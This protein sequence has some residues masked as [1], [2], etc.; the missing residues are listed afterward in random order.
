MATPQLSPGILVREIDLTVGR[1]DNIVNNIGAI[2]GPFQIGPIDEPIEV[3]NQAELLETFG[4]P[5]STDRQYEYWMSASSYLSYGGVLKVVRTDDSDLNNANAGVGV[6]TN[7][8][9][10]IKNLDDYEENYS[11]ATNFTYAAKNP[12]KWADGLK[13]CYIDNLADQTLGITTTGI[14]TTVN[15]NVTVG[16][17]VTS[18]ITGAIPGAGSTSTF[19]GYLEGIV[20]GITSTAGD[21]EQ[22]IDVKILKRVSSAGTVTEIDYQKNNALASFT[23]SSTLQF[24]NSGVSTAYSVSPASQVD[25]YDQQQLDLNTPINWNT[26]APRPVDSNFVSS[27]SSRNDGI[28]IVVVD[29]SGSVSGVSGNILEKH[30]F[31]SKAKDAT[32][33]GEAPIKTYYKDYLANNS[34]NIFAGHSPSNAADSFHETTPTAGGF[35]SARVPFTIGEGQWGQDA[36][37]IVFSG[38]GNKS[39]SLTG[40]KDYGTDGVG[41]TATLGN[42]QTSYDLFTNESEEEVDFLIMGPGLGDRLLTQ[43]KANQLISIAEARKDCIAVIGPDRSEVVDI[44]DT[45]A[46]TNLLTYYSPLTS[47]SYAVF[48]TGWKYVYD[49]FNNAFVYVPCNA[50]VAG[51]MVRTEIEA[52]PWFSPAGAQRGQINDAIKLAYNPSK[53]HRDQLYGQR[54]NPIIN[55]RGAGII[56]F[57]DKTGLSYSSAFDRINVRRLFL[58]VEQALES[59]ADAQLFE[60]NDE[61]TRANFVNAVEPYLRDVQAKRGLFD[62]VVKCDERNNTPDIIDNN[63]FRAD[64]FLKPTKSINYVTLTFVA[65]RSGVEFEEVVGTV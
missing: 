1:V 17:A 64:I 28:H 60:I 26:I 49:R 24:F 53:A 8:S 21:S 39:Y 32:R 43:A 51:T 31:L 12:G 65:T 55:K 56:L 33:D 19:T 2:A 36:Q 58:T 40:G 38:I 48:D 29:D 41:F 52:F 6:G 54:I 59:V 13:V 5:L 22:S 7:T 20:T 61:I 11:T 35:S 47:S 45:T 3:S 10:K 62:F 23:T 25:W 4:Q 9:L 63:E 27:R 16:C 18:A 37:G 34:A 50:D 42:L 15:F 46:L 30:T 14:S 44:A 57:G